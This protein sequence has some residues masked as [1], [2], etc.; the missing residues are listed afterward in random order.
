M[1]PFSAHPS[2]AGSASVVHFTT[3]NFA[4]FF[5][6]VF[7]VAGLLREKPKHHKIFLLLAS[8]F[9][10]A[11]LSIPLI[12]LLLSSSLVNWGLGEWMVRNEDQEKRRWGLRAGVVAN[13]GLL[14]TF[15]YYNFFQQTVQSVADLFGLQSH[16]PLLEAAMPLGISFFTFQGLGYVIDLYR[17]RGRRADSALD[18]LLYIAFFPKLISGPLARPKDFLPQIAEGPLPMVV[19]LPRAAALIASG[20]FKKAVLASILGPRLVD[21]AFLT[22][23]NFSNGALLMAAYAY[24]IQLYC[25]F[26]GYTDMARG[27][28]LLLGYRLPENF[29]APYSATDPGVFWHRWHATFSSWLREYVYFPLGG[30]KGTFL[31]TCRN[32]VVTFTICGLWHGATWGYILWGAL[33]GVVLCFHKAIRDGRR[34]FGLEGREPWWWLAGGWFLTFHIVVLSRILFQASD[35]QTAGV[36]FRRMLDF[37]AAGQGF[38][39]WV[40]L[41]SL[42]G[43]SLHFIGR[44]IRESFIWLHERTPR[45]LKPLFWLGVGIAILALRPG[46]VAP[47]IYFRF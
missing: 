3:L 23:E 45:M 22:P 1:P 10:Y 40:V 2:P 41:A 32:L 39:I 17:K 19:E 26:S 15:K 24:S 33:H 25:D 37:D 5:L 8:Y 27:I 38:D 21:D 9:F 36:F 47:Y 14:G 16:L 28:G 43:F 46:D 4:Y 42:I 11:K 34:K 44:Q 31:K 35:L 20:L 13:L 29:N 18:F 12:F 6:I 30:S 7:T